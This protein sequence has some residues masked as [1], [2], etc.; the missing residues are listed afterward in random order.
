MANSLLLQGKDS[1]AKSFDTKHLNNHP[2]ALNI[3]INGKEVSRQVEMGE[4][5]PSA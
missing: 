1:G 4:D 3:I 2:K 5:N